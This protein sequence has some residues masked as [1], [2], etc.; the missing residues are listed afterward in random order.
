LPAAVGVLA[1]GRDAVPE[2]VGAEACIKVNYRSP[3]G[4]RS[5]AQS[6]DT[7][8]LPQA[9]VGTHPMQKVALARSD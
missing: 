3:G 7:S 4:W 9:L 6:K 5:P 1:S 2:L 8:Q